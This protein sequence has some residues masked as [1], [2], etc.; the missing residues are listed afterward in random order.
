MMAVTRT[1]YLPT[2]HDLNLYNKAKDI[3]QK[4]EESVSNYILKA[5]KHYMNLETN[6]VNYP[7]Y[8]LYVGKSGQMKKKKFYGIYLT[9]EIKRYE[10]IEEETQIYLTKKEN[11]IVYHRKR[12]M[13]TSLE[14]ADYQI[15]SSLEE[16]QNISENLYRSAKE[17]LDITEAEFLDV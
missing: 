17:K 5:L 12:N 11:I 10:N 14:N 15:Y 13:D 3:A 16:V 4:N 9:S 8:V 1:I 6:K 2:A 7:L